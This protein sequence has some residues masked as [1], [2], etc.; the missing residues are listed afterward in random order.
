MT[1]GGAGGRPRRPLS[2]WPPERPPSPAREGGGGHLGP[3][4]NPGFDLSRRNPQE[5]F[6]LIQR[7]GSG[8]YGDVYKVKAGAARRRGRGVPTLSQ[9][10]A[11]ELAPPS[12]G[13]A[14][15]WEQSGR[16]SC[17]RP[18]LCCLGEQRAKCVTPR[19]PQPLPEP[20]GERDFC[21]LPSCAH[22]Q[23]K[24]ERERATLLIIV[25]RGSGRLLH[26]QGQRDEPDS[27][28]LA[29]SNLPASHEPG[30]VRSRL[31][32]AAHQALVVVT[33]LC[34]ATSILHRQLSAFSTLSIPL[35]VYFNFPSNDFFFFWKEQL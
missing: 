24:A 33:I 6:E 35:S 8:T 32:A 1:A 5:D 11:P 22:L 26:W 19:P 25:Q 4:M 13:D 31:G 17:G 30:I 14:G 10:W 29:L 15:A 23:G 9:A 16:R 12:S 3:A 7:I 20:S 18:G 34:W 27:R 2:V 21:H 28:G